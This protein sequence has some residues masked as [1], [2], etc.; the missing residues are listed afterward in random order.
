MFFSRQADR[1]DEGPDRAYNIFSLCLKRNED[2]LTLSDLWLVVRH[3]MKWVIAIPVVCALV[4]AGYVFVAGQAKEKGEVAEATLTATDPSA[5]VDSASLANLMDALAQAAV[6]RMDADVAS[7]IVVES[8]PTTQSVTFTATSSDGLNA[9]ALANEAARETADA[10]KTA[11]TAQSDSYLDGVDAV[12]KN[13]GGEIASVVSGTTTADRAAALRSCIFTISEATKSNSA[14]SAGPAKYAIVGLLGGLFLVICV[15][16]FVDSI[17]RP[18][19]CRADIGEVT[20]L[21]VLSEGEGLSAMERLWTNIQ[22][23]SDCRPCSVCLLFVSPGSCTNVVA[24]LQQA[25][26]LSRNG[27]VVGSPCS[28]GNPTDSGKS[29]VVESYVASS[30]SVAGVLA[31]HCADVTVVVARTWVDKMGEL[32]DVLS[33]LQIARANVAGVAVL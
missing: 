25:I 6:S 24:T 17:R 12:E 11:L 33:E 22:F 19:K 23:V 1:V 27:A 13:T 31:A 32:S 29:V 30:D 18:L 9:V 15:L 4:A 10:V 26:N 7:S 20:D 2:G 8:D 14:D 3:Y 16:V 5:L 21:P 28:G